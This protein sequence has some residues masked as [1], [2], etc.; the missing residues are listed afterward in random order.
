MGNRRFIALALATALLGMTA[1]PV[2]AAPTY[3][4]PPA[5]GT[6]DYQ[7]GGAYAP[8]PDVDILSRDRLEQPVA[9]LYNICYVN[10]FQT[11]PNEP[12]QSKS[13]P[14]YGTTA[15]WQKYHPKLLLRDSKKR[16]VIDKAWNEAI[17][18]IRTTA[19]R[20]ALYAVQ[21]TW[22][23]GCATDGF[24]AVEPD[25][26]DVH[27]RSKKLLTTGAIRAYLKLVIPYTHRAGLAIAQKNASD[28]FGSTGPSLGFDFAIA[29]ECERYVECDAY[30]AYRDL[31]YEIEY[32][33]DNPVVTRGGISQTVFEWACSDRGSRH[34]IILRDRDVV[35]V[36]SD[37]Y[38]NSSC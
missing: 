28:Q 27:L 36:G 17:F 2:S 19:K 21:K 26:L 24:D 35:P 8:A 20:K 6:F 33:D 3:E 32:T 29:E 5:N 12:G 38:V 18:D 7:L 30:A 25:N 34:S 11:Q 13:R 1:A 14:P 37:G 9:G 23:R 10:L 4:L 22:I 15:W 31:L 16:L